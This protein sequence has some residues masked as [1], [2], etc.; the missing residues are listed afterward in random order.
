MSFSLDK[1]QNDFIADIDSQ[2]A[3]EVS[4]YDNPSAGRDF[5]RYVVHLAFLHSVAHFIVGELPLPLPSC[6]AF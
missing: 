2:W 5:C 1:T 4:R 6:A 3:S